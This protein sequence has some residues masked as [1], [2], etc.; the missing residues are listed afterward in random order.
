MT[1]S[2]CLQAGAVDVASLLK[3]PPRRRSDEERKNAV[4][5]LF[6]V[7]A[8][9]SPADNS[10]EKEVWH[11]GSK[12]ADLFSIVNRT[13]HVVRQEFVLY[14]DYFVWTKKGGLRT[15]SVNESRGI[16]DVV[17]ATDD[18]QLDA[19][20]NVPRLERGKAAL[21]SYSGKDAYLLHMRSLLVLAVQGNDVSELSAV[22]SALSAAAG[23]K[24]RSEAAAAS[25]AGAPKAQASLWPYL[26]AG[27]VAGFV[28]VALIW[29]M[30][31]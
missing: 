22:T 28:V 14:D 16:K 13:G 3:M 19:S 4:E 15:G 8:V 6:R 24:L 25:G 9:E 27:T 11:Q 5:S 20:P 10:G 1:S 7:R 18:I 30:I 12:G 21:N 31:R 17:K 29:L 26:A 2:D 23:Q